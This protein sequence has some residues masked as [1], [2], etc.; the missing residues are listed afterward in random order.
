MINKIL[1]LLLI[2]QTTAFAEIRIRPH[3]WA[4][5]MI[6]ADLD[7]FYK[8]DEKVYRSEQPDS[9]TFKQIEAFGIKSILNL[10]QFNSDDDEAEKTDLRLHRVKMNAGS[11]SY[12]QIMTALK[13]IKAADG[14][15]LI[16]CWHGSDRTGVVSASYRVVFQGWGK[17]KAIDEMKYGDYGYHQKIYPELAKMIKNLNVNFFRKE[18]GIP[19]KK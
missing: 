11:V 12:P 6:G 5:R 16:H 13:K 1:I 2:A 4:S 9:Q 15:V 17:D 18:L 7:N 10:R 14:P 8:L 3:D 19:G